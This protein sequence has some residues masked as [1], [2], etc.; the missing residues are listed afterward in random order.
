MLTI[1]RPVFAL[2]GIGG[3]I[4]LLLT[5]VEEPKTSFSLS[6]LLEDRFDLMEDFLPKDEFE[7]DEDVVR[8]FLALSCSW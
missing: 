3:F 1:L 4:A 6:S 2:I 7:S 5:V 8:A